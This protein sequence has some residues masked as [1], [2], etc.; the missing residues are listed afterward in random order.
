MNFEFA[1]A[2]RIVF[3]KGKSNQ[4][5]KIWKQLGKK[6]MYIIGNSFKKY[7]SYDEIVT[8]HEKIV[9]TNEPSTHL[10]EEISEKTKK[11]GCDVIISIGGGSVIDSGKA[12]AALTPNSG[13]LLDYLEII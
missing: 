1:T 12:A 2:S 8:T 5:P 13:S 7:P 11:S 9:V 3:G 4:I 6:P 10:I